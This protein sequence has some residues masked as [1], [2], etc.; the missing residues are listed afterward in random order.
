MTFEQTENG[1]LVAVAAAAAAAAVVVVVSS[2]AFV[3]NW[4][5]INNKLKRITSPPMRCVDKSTTLCF[6]P[7]IYESI[8]VKCGKMESKYNKRNL[9]RSNNKF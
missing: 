8:Q 9:L 4:A 3:I 1:L 6:I 5:Q 2:C 7:S